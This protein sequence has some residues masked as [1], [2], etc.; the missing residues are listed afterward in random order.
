[1]YYSCPRFTVY[2]LVKECMFSWACFPQKTDKSDQLGTSKRT[3]SGDKSPEDSRKIV[4]SA[5]KYNRIKSDLKC[6]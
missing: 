6:L 5:I 3:L 1:M 2:D 4:L